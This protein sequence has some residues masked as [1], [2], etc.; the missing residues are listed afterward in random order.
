MRKITLWIWFLGSA[1][2]LVDAGVSLHF[3]NR[4]H[5]ILALCIAFLFLGAGLFYNRQ[6]N[7]PG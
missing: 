2:W 4:P 3:N 5:A 7:R 1:A 6:G